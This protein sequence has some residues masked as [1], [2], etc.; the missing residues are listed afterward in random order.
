MLVIDG[1]NLILGRLST[2]VAKSLLNGEEIHLINAE[3]L[4]II[5]NKHVLLEKYRARRRAQHKGTPE[6]SPKWPRVP[7]Y[8]VRKTVRGMLPWRTT[9]GRAAFKKLRVYSGNPKNFEKAVKIDNA[10]VDVRKNFITIQ[11]LCKMLGYSG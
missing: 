4:V 3:K 2:H 8:L 1:T 9:K 10:A 7:H 11:D 5:G 6:F